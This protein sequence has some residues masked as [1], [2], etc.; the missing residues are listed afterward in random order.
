MEQNFPKSVP[1]NLR[2]KILHWDDERSIGNS[3]I[4]SLK[5][6][7]KFNYDVEN[8]NATHVMGFDTVKEAVA[9]LR[10]VFKCSCKECELGSLK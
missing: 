7:F 9:E 3:I 6:G 2:A 1:S 8:D 5:D 10:G 4:V